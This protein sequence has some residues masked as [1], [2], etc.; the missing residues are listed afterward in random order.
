MPKSP[1]TVPGAELA[2]LVAPIIWRLKAM[3]FFPSQTF[4]NNERERESW[5]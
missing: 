2:G 1:L 5:N 4:P 3:T